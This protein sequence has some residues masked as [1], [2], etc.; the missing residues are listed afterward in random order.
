MIDHLHCDAP[1]FRAAERAGNVA[2]ERGLGFFV[3]LGSNGG[4]QRF[5][6]VIG[7]EE[8]G[9]AN[10]EAFLVVV[11]VDEPGRPSLS[12]SRSISAVSTLGF[13]PS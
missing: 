10:V 6:G 5:V 4:L 1:R 9:V 13:R 2:V 7:A 8:V 3:D 11:G 12:R